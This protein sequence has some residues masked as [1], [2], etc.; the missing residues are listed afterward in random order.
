MDWLTHHATVGWR[1]ILTVGQ[2]TIPA[3]HTARDLEWILTGS[4]LQKRRLEG[5]QSIDALF[6][7]WRALNLHVKSAVTAEQVIP[8]MPRWD[9]AKG[10][11]VGVTNPRSVKLSRI[12]RDPKRICYQRRLSK[13][14][15]KHRIHSID[16]ELFCWCV[17]LIK[18][19]LF[20]MFTTVCDLL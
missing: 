16:N 5:L 2:C 17:S 7:W 6:K 14:T 8:H 11:S 3:L 13:C 4:R 20:S 12:Q 9:S 19:L 15:R 10:K 18:S 1:S